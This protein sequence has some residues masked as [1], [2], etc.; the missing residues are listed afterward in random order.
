MNMVSILVSK[1][2]RVNNDI[3]NSGFPSSHSTNSVSIAL[4][5][6]QWMFKL[7]DR[8]GWPTVLFSWLSTSSSLK[9][10]FLYLTSQLVLAVY[11]TSV[12]GG[13]VYT[14]MHSIGKCFIYFSLSSSWNFTN[15]FQP[16]LLEGVS[17]VWLVGYFGLQLVIGTRHGWIRA[18]GQV[19]HV[20][21][22]E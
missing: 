14:G 22:Y 9:I 1:K 5:L 7:Q 13:R 4:Y 18:L 10:Q 6:G 21:E 19:G 2:N 15:L 3:L 8:L 17:W 11:M 12:I 20:K 16:I